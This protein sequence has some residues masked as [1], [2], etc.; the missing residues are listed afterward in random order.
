MRGHPLYS[1]RVTPVIRGSFLRTVLH[2]PYVKRHLWRRDTCDVGT[3]SLGYWGVPF[4][5]VL[6]CFPIK[7]MRITADI[8]SAHVLHIYSSPGTFCV[9]PA[10]QWSLVGGASS[11]DGDVTGWGELGAAV[12]G[13][14][15][16]WPYPCKAIRN[17]TNN[18]HHK[19]MFTY[20]RPCRPRCW[21]GSPVVV[22]WTFDHWVAGSNPFKDIINFTSLSI[23]L[24]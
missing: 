2:L 10:C 18:T 19:L 5:Q 21:Q 13:H 11:V 20:S 9:P 23:Q 7:T 1:N 6:L 14:D 12:A 4:N 22:C 3:L 8:Q 15:V 24:Q 16:W 17:L